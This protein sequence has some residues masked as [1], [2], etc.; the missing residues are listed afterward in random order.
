MAV[1]AVLLV[2]GCTGAAGDGEE[3]GGLWRSEGFGLYLDIDGGIDVYEHTAVS[4]GR[5]ASGSM[6]GSDGFTLIG[7][8]GLELREPARLIRFD[9][10]DVLPERCADPFRSDDPART[11]AVLVATM[12]EHYA[13]FDLRDTGWA[14]RR[15]EADAS[16]GADTGPADLLAAIQELLAPLGDAQVRI[17]VD[18]PD[19]LPGGAWSARPAPPGADALAD[20][21]RAGRVPLLE[22]EAEVAE[23]GAVVSGSL[24]DGVGYLA[25]TRLA[26][27][28]DDAGEEEQKLADAVDAALGRLGDDAVVLDL[29]VN[30]GGR[31]ELALLVASRF[32]PAETLVAT[33]EVR[34]GGTDR[35]TDGGDLTVSPLPTGTFA[36][37]LVVLAGPGTAGAAETLL[38]ALRHAPDTVVVG[39]PTAGSLSPLLVRSLPNGWTFG[40]S[41]QRVRDADG[42][43]WEGRGIPPDV[44]AA[45]EP[46]EVLRAGLQA[47]G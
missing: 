43:L 12:E 7:E 24:P 2:A 5:V 42:E 13:F 22:G 27:F 15:T 32:V 4:C 10:V 26:G 29:R 37:R 19:L 47:A 30:R 18:D 3:F 20:D 1:A 14:A 28:D 39:E 34:V 31:E 11:L 40:L 41:H 25:I 36:G 46:T 45:G 16:V 8:D 23:D 44:V 21:I 9:R 35:Y 33:R 38:L 17:A 6:R